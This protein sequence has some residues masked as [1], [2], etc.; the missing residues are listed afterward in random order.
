MLTWPS[1]DWMCRRRKMMSIMNKMFCA[2]CPSNLIGSIQAALQKQMYLINAFSVIKKRRQLV[3]KSCFKS[4]FLWMSAK[5]EGMIYV[6]VIKCVFW[7]CFVKILPLCQGQ[8]SAVMCPSTLQRFCLTHSEVQQ[9]YRTTCWGG[10]WRAEGCSTK[11][12]R[13]VK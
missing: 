9:H 4:H 8:A 3:T 1:Q 2:I 5:R 10:G 13:S 12:S 6:K 11:R 7:I